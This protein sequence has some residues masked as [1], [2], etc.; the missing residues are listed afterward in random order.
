LKDDDRLNDYN[1]IA[2][3]EISEENHYES[4]DAMLFE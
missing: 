4:E 2:E 3:E 1:S